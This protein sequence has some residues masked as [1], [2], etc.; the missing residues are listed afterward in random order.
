[1]LQDEGPGSADPR[2]KIPS[3]TRGA[4]NKA[5]RRYRPAPYVIKPYAH[6]PKTSVGQ[7]PPT[8]VVV[9]GFDPLVPDPQI[10]H[11]FSSFGEIAELKNQIHKT[12]GSYLGV[13][14][15]RYRD[16]KSVR[17]GPPRSATEAAHKA[18]EECKTGQHRI[19]ERKVRATLDRDGT[20]LRKSLVWAAEHL[21]LHPQ[22]DHKPPEPPKEAIRTSTP[23]PPPTAPK[24]PSGRSS[25]PVV[26][27]PPPPPP[28]HHRAPA[29]EDAPRIIETRP[30]LE[31]IKREPYIFIDHR[32]V[33]VIAATVNHLRRRLRSYDIKRIRCDRSGYFLFFEDSRHGEE[34]TVRCYMRCNNER[35]FNNDMVMECQQYGNPSY[36]RSPSPQ[37]I[38]LEKRE[39]Q[40]RDQ[41]EKE[42]A[43]DI[44]EEKKERA[45]NLDPVLAM[46]D[47]IH[48]EM[49]AKLLDDVKARIVPKALCDY[50]N[51]DRHTEKRRRLNIID[52]WLKN[53]PSMGPLAYETATDLRLNAQQSILSGIRQ[54]LTSRSVKVSMLPR[55]RK[56]VTGRENSGFTDERRRVKTPKKP[57]TKANFRLHNFQNDDDESDDELRTR[58]TRDTEDLESR[59]PSRTS[60][61]SMDDDSQIILPTPKKLRRSAREMSWTDVPSRDEESLHVTHSERTDS[62]DPEV[63]ALQHE[64]ES[65]PLK[66]RKRKRELL[67]EIAARKKRKEDDEL[68][69]VDMDESTS[70]ALK[71]ESSF[72]EPDTAS[73]DILAQESV[74][75]IEKK[76]EDTEAFEEGLKASKAKKP[77]K[78]K[79]KSKKQIFEEREA[80]KKAQA[81]ELDTLIEPPEVAEIMLTPTPE[82]EAE[83]DQD[84]T[85]AEQRPSDIIWGTS[86]D[87]PRRTVED[88]PDLVLDVD[89][90][91]HLLKDDEDIRFLKQS[92]IDSPSANIKVP[93]IFAWRQK[94]IKALN[95]NGG[96]GPVYTPTQI[97]GY[98]VPNPSGCA[99]T[100]GFKKIPQAEKSKYLPHR[101]K[102][103]E[104]RE[105]AKAKAE[106][107]PAAAAAEKAKMDK[108]KKDSKTTSRSN[109]ANHRRLAADM[110]ATGTRGVAGKEALT[111][112]TN[113]GNAL[114]FNQLK[115]RAKDVRFDRSPIHNWGLFAEE[116]IA[117]QDMIIEYVGE[118]IRQ[119]VA[120][121]REVA[122]TKQGIGSSYLFRLDDYYLIDATKKGGIARFINHSCMPNC[123][124]KIIRVEGTRRIVIYA[125]RDIEA[126]K[127]LPHSSYVQVYREYLLT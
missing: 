44:E 93:S 10:K 103:L 11:L 57:A 46:V 86:V 106:Q 60:M 42:A 89:G 87:R 80:L 123:T 125:L 3:Y 102:V 52:P 107:D 48:E 109:R 43:L 127:S 54:P 118:K 55:I 47:I 119:A 51:P 35:L 122:Y 13:C 12:T 21:G 14:W 114:R 36:E 69:S 1:M 85:P 67:Q 120:D 101:V 22:Q 82:A 92:I 112:D 34:E 74:A 70:P 40:K 31:Q 116:P 49:K 66:S 63:T 56:G 99:R 33:P 24:G 58:A 81:A 79:K 91:Q 72:P 121:R 59:P 5:S 76:I 78:A 26:P 28:E 71:D 77:T 97:E 6:D 113:E 94:E 32:H 9:T 18:H 104:A 75:A 124:A 50:L 111:T 41:L 105:K 7:G 53:N 84:E 8:R 38:L 37:R 25:R 30:I 45:L 20:V 19:G 39:K 62:V 27:P 98:Y 115:K 64:F 65:L 16:S 61:T 17:G 83:M 126:R 100:E 95:R 96:G 110:A 68:F 15:I 29:R 73:E 88:D 23:G 4:A 90:W 2:L 117:A 108:L